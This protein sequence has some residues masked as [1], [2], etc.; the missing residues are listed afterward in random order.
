M[1]EAAMLEKLKIRS[2][3]GSLKQTKISLCSYEMFQAELLDRMLLS[4]QR[5]EEAFIDVNNR[6]I[7]N[8]NARKDRLNMIN[9]RIQ[10]ISAKI[11]A[12]YEQKRLM[13]IISPA[14]LP[15][16]STSES[17]S[18]HPHQSMFYDREEITPL[19][20]EINEGAKE[21]NLDTSM[22]ELSAITL[23]KKLYNTRL[24]NERGDLQGIVSGAFKDIHEIT[25]LM[26]SLRK[27]RTETMG[28]LNI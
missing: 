15:K 10:N 8:V 5:T 20:E 2:E 1:V 23:K 28:E 4:I 27:Y 17:A 6:I 21:A 22:P 13:R 24:N 14:N 7:S 26:L 16:I 9:S 3:S 11:L 25:K 12:L 18:N 19:P